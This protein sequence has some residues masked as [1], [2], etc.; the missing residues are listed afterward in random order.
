MI[1]IQH[2]SNNA[3][4][5]APRGWDHNGTPC[6]ALPITR[7]ECDGY[8]VVASFWR[9][10]AEELAALNAGAAVELCVLGHRMPPVSVTVKQPGAN[11]GA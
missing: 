8:T 3:T 11:D 1:P 5:A 2:P 10:T 7:T 4:L 6:A 9:P